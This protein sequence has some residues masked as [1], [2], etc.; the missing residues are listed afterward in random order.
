M[1]SETPAGAVIGVAPMRVC[2]DTVLTN[3]EGYAAH[4]DGSLLMLQTFLVVFRFLFILVAIVLGCRPFTYQPC[5]QGVKL[6]AAPVTVE[7]SRKVG[8]HE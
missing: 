7:E 8:R 1:I 3:A 2:G 5:R 4:I 6:A